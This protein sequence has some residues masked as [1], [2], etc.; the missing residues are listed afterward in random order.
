MSASSQQW[1]KETGIPAIFDLDAVAP[2]PEIP[3]GMVPNT[4]LL[5]RFQVKKDED[6]LYAYMKR[7]QRF[8]GKNSVIMGNQIW[9]DWAGGPVC[10]EAVLPDDPE[11]RERGIVYIH[12]TIY[13]PKKA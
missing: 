9:I 11:E 2:F 10:Y 13:V 1:A 4:Q 3:A 12:R 5:D 7:L 8:F 6:P